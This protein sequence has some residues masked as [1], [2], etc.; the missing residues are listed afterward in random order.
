MSTSADELV[1]DYLDRLERELAE[2]PSARRRELVQEIS[3]HIAEARAALESETEADVRNLL[4]RMGE[5]ADIAAEAREAPAVPPAAAAAPARRRS[6]A[7]D[8]A[9]LILLLVGGVVFPVLGW[10]V[11]VLLLWVSDSW[12][13]S[14]KLIGTFVVP[15]GLALPVYL[16]LAGTYTE[17]CG[18]SGGVPVTCVG[19]PSGPMHALGIVLMLALFVLPFVTTAFLARRRSRSL[20]LA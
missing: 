4:D 10:F 18:G 11:G 7:L 8:V 2:F 17:S 13:T 19:E 14:E 1:A 20:A 5:P 3:E 15:G 6:S 9:A 12:T 16:S